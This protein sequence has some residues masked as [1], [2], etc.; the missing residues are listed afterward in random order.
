MKAS[1]L[2][3]KIAIV[4]L[5]YV[6]LPLAVEFSKKYTVV[7]FDTNKS[8]I[9]ELVAGFDSTRELSADQFQSVVNLCFSDDENDLEQC[10]V[11]II[12]V[13]TPIDE[14]KNPDLS[15]LVSAS[16][17]VARH[18][19]KGDHV[20]Y[21][22]TV[23]PGCTEEICV[24]VLESASG[25]ILDQDFHVGYSPERVNPG[26]RERTLTKI[27]KVTSGSSQYAAE[28]VD[29][30]YGSIISAG[31][32]KAESIK[33]AEAAKVIE[34][35]QRDLN[36]SLMNELALIFD[37]IGIDTS[38]VLRAA[39]TKWN[40]LPFEP[41]LVGGHC[42]GVD[43]YYL[44]SKA[45]SIGYQPEIILAGRRLNDSIPKFIASKLIKSLSTKRLLSREATVLILGLTFKENCPDTRNTKVMDIASEL[46]EFGV[47]VDIYDPV[48]DSEDGKL[49]AGDYWVDKPR[50][51]KYEGIIIA[52]PHSEFIEMGGET[53]RMFGI[54]NCAVF[55]VKS[56]F[57]RDLGFLRL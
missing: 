46:E 28:F 16:N 10:N 11:F 20:I 2:D 49:V 25:W 35:T 17:L 6:G 50:R 38:A 57:D 36:I 56:K 37:K 42:I 26:D 43:P 31:T 30:L 13:P 40:F 4:G 9:K 24:P 29:E 53:I 1:E 15:I 7:G 22:S 19:N 8:R 32:F 44:T 23:F 18:L 45:Q 48:A 21:E 39:G 34:N 51:L 54:Q 27:I 14:S 41:G 12:A 3:I 5:G 47:K 33:V 55:D 52:V